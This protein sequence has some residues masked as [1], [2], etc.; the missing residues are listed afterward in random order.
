MDFEGLCCL[1][2]CVQNTVI[3]ASN[4]HKR[5]WETHLKSSNA[6]VGFAHLEH[7]SGG[8]SHIPSTQVHVQHL[9]LVRPRAGPGTTLITGERNTV[10]QKRRRCHHWARTPIPGLCDLLSWG[11]A[12]VIRIVDQLVSHPHVN[13]WNRN[14]SAQV[15]GPPIRK[16]SL[17]VGGWGFLPSYLVSPSCSIK[18]DSPQTAAELR[19]QEKPGPHSDSVQVCVWC[20]V[21]F[22]LLFFI[23]FIWVCW[24]LVAAHGIF[25]AL[26]RIFHCGAWSL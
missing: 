5:C 14:P 13:K 3:S 12:S 11:A 6:G 25:V 7:I 8:S 15:H 19:G 4:Q 9:A 22:N 10:T 20:P 2:Q 23:L 26:G 17:F 21:F 16:C 18:M 24:V 1:T